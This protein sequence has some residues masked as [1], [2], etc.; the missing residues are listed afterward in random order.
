MSRIDNAT[1]GE[2]GPEAIIPLSSPSAK[3]MMGGG[4]PTQ[5]TANLILDGQV[6]ATMVAQVDRTD[7]NRVGTER[8]INNRSIQ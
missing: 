5:L 4:G 8:Q 1:I 2:R 3:Q 6:L 7:P